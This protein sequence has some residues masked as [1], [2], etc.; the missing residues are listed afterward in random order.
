MQKIAECTPGIV[1]VFL[2][3]LQRKINDANY[4][5]SQQYTVVQTC[6]ETQLY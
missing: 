6:I 4:K 5:A 1:E 2:L 3:G